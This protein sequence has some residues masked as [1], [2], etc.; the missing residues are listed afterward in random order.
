MLLRFAL[1]LTTLALVAGC[2]DGDATDDAV[3]QRATTV[4]QVPPPAP[5]SGRQREMR[6]VVRAW[7]A[8]LNEGDLEGI[9]RLFRLPA[10]VAQGQTSYRLL[11][12]EHLRI[13][14]SGLPC[15]GR[16]VSIEIN[17]RYATAV[18]RLGHGKR[19]RCDAPGTLAAARFEIVKDKIRSW[20]QI[21]V[22]R[23]A[24]TA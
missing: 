12:R 15:S 22:T 14:H 21:P 10:Y 6:A 18:F 1:V 11:T 2:G 24:P 13:W 5:P 16:I 17:G 23:P 4:P 19:S 7:S 20:E 8:R 9:A 3:M